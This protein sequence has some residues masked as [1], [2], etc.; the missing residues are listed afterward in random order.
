MKGRIGLVNKDIK[1]TIL[2]KR[3]H[4][5]LFQMDMNKKLPEYIG[6]YYHIEGCM[7]SQ[8]PPKKGTS[9]LDTMKDVVLTDRNSI[10]VDLE[11]V[12]H[13]MVHFY[14]TTQEGE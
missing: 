11:V 12:Q 7:I 6:E 8:E 14:N 1:A 10:F 13:N 4:I 5:T 9:A 3:H 2:P